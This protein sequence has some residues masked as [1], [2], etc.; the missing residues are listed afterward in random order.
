MRRVQLQGGARGPHARR[1]SCTLSVR[2]REPTKQMGPSHRSRAGT[3]QR[4]QEVQH[5]LL[6][7]LREAVEP[8]DHPVRLRRIAR[9][10]ATALVGANGDEQI[11]G[12]SIVQEED[13][14]TE[15]PE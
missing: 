1:T 6:L 7:A 2:P 8:L 5:V 3:S 13:A 10:A 11:L 12:P 9:E 14:L 15:A 4:P